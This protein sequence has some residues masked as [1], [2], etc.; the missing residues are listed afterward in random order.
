MFVSM[1]PKLGFVE[2]KEKH[3]THQ[4]A[5]KQ[6]MGT[7]LALEGLGQQMQK[8]RGHQSPSGQAQHVLGVAAQNAKAQPSRHPNAANTGHQSAHQNCQKSHCL[9]PGHRLPPKKPPLK[10]GLCAPKIRPRHCA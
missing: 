10:G 2:Q 3:Q 6:L 9:F 1:V 7:G 5:Q 8:S 4:Q